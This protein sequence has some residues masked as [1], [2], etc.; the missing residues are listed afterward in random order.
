MFPSQIGKRETRCVFLLWATSHPPSDSRSEQHSG[1]AAMNKLENGRH[2][3]VP[4]NWRGAGVSMRGRRGQE[5][6]EGEMGLRFQT[7]M[8]EEKKRHLNKATEK[9]AHQKVKER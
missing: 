9:L 1:E 8:T 5:G 6:Q 4:T 7:E 2:S 3:S